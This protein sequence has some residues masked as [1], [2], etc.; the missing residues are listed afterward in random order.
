MYSPETCQINSFVEK[1]QEFVSNKIN[2]G[3]YI[4]N[5]SMLRRIELK[6]TSIE[7]EVFPFMAQDGQLF[8]MELKGRNSYGLVPVL[9]AI[10]STN[11][12]WGK[13]SYCLRPIIPVPLKDLKL[14]CLL[15]PWKLYAE[16]LKISLRYCFFK[17]ISTLYYITK[18]LVVQ[19]SL[20]ISG[21]VN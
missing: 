14:T 8:A 10:P 9:T 15:H 6:P 2:A 3:L 7:K 4:F 13:V 18:L 19:I 11:I 21:I 17:G 5:P 16:S 1:P 12:L 20:G